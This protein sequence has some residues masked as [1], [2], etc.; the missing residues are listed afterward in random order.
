MRL[1]QP[2]VCKKIESMELV[3]TIWYNIFWSIARG[4]DYNE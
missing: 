2:E 3:F 1:Q 4:D